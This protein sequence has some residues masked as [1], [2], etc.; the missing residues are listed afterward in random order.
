M[1]PFIDTED[2]RLS[3]FGLDVDTGSYSIARRYLDDGNLPPREAI[4]IEEFLNYF[5]YGDAPPK[6][7]DFAIHADLAPAPFASGERYQVLRFGIRGR[8][9]SA[10]NRKPATLIFVVDVSGSMAREN[11]LGLVIS[12]LER[13]LE[14]LRGDDRVGLV[15]YGSRGEVVLEP[16]GDHGTIRRAVQSLRS[17]GSTNAEEGLA[18][19]YDLASRHFRGDAI[20][21]IILCSDG[22]ATCRRRRDDPTASVLTVRG[23]ARLALGPADVDLDSGQCIAVTGPSGAGKTLLLRAIADLD[24]AEGEVL[25]DGV[26][27]DAMAAPDWRARVTYVPAEAGWWEETVRPHFFPVA[28]RVA[29]G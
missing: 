15:I 5:D 9:V 17:G 8:E 23:L 24:P 20:N 28:G 2:D 14:Q 11:R 16:T 12:S 18:L 25:L 7:G 10:E 29:A 26:S 13:L 22:G 4:R 21:R 3:T 19:A 27:R 1:N 6:R